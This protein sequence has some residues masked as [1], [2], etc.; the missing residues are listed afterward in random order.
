MSKFHKL[1]QVL[2]LQAPISKVLS[3]NSWCSYSVKI[4]SSDKKK[5]K[6]INNLDKECLSWHRIWV[7]ED[8][9]ER[10][11]SQP[12][13]L[14]PQLRLGTPSSTKHHH[15]VLAETAAP[16]CHQHVWQEGKSLLERVLSNN[17][18]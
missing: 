13:L 14:A 3:V 12:C 8:W 4:V 1:S 7:K 6:L 16:A 5:P 18:N 2:F 15:R 9:K 11:E 17:L 10:A